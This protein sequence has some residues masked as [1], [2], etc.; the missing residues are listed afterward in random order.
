M[1]ISVSNHPIAVDSSD[2]EDDDDVRRH[3]VHMAICAEHDNA[4]TPVDACRTPAGLTHSSLRKRL[5]FLVNMQLQSLVL[6][7]CAMVVCAV[8]VLAHEAIVTTTLICLALSV[9][10]LAL[11]ACFGKSAAKPRQRHSYTWHGTPSK[12]K[13]YI[14][15]TS[16]AGQ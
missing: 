4:N 10:I 5:N 6:A 2:D 9:T 3:V 11:A 15:S 7:M 13:I 16:A 12:V 14:S 1:T 8:L